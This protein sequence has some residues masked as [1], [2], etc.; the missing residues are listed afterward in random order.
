MVTFTHLTHKRLLASWSFLLLIILVLS[1]CSNPT[2]GGSNNQ[3]TLPTIPV[4]VLTPGTPYASLP[5]VRPFIDTW[6]NIHL[7]QNFDYK[8]DNPASIAQYYDFVW[9]AS[10]DNVAAFRASNPN[11]FLSY[12]F[13]FFRDSGTFASKSATHDL[14]Y[15]K[16]VHPDWILYQCDRQTPAYEDGLPNI[17]F[18][19]ANPAV[20][21]WQL[22]TYAQP[23]SE[24]GYDAIAA[25]NVNMEN[26]IGACGY[27]NNGQW[28]QR[29]TGQTNDSQWRTD[30]ISWA[31][32]MQQALHHL[33]HPL[34]LIPNLGVG[35]LTPGDPQL[36]QMVSHIDGILDE[37]GFTQYG[38]GYLTGDNWVQDINFI[39]SIQQE[40]KAY[41]VVNEFPSVGQSEIQWALA[42]YLMAK[43]HSAAV[44]ITTIQSYG[45]DTRHSEYAAAIGSPLDQMYQGQNIYFRD[46]SHGLSMVN[47]S[48][49]ATRSVKLPV[50]SHYIDLYGHQAPQTVTLPPHSGLVLL[51]AAA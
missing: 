16:N 18:N 51:N 21:A 27:Y 49:T 20:I 41:F 19:F 13:S 6:N 37:A 8:I 5:S 12:Y 45:F 11:I 25:D 24:N 36:Q 29:Y 26:L 1:S 35:S 31:T 44:S 10:P 46:Y 9:G 33:K 2:Q 43:E 15:W 48:P 40:H 30:V 4:P 23:A 22:Q 3:N 42:S 14:A 38:D 47:P 17:P 32:E 28:V 50:G 34:A 39:E 7:F